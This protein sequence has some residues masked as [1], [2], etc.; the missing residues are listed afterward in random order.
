MVNKNEIYDYNNLF[1]VHQNPIISYQKFAKLNKDII[2]FNNDLESLLVI[3]REIKYEIKYHFDNVVR[4]VY[5]EAKLD[6]YGSSLYQLDIESSDL[7]L[8]ICT[9]EQ[10]NLDDLVAYLNNI[11]K[12]KKYLNINFIK[13]ASIP[14]IK[15]DVDF[16]K[17]N[18]KKVKEM[19]NKLNNNNYFQ[20][21]VK[22]N[23]YNDTN[24]I[25]V[26]ISLNSINYK[27]LNFINQGI[28]QF[29]QIIFLIKILKK[30]LIYKHM[31]NSYKGGMSSYCLF[32]ILYSYLKFYTNY[33]QSNSIENNYGSLL[34][35]FLFYYIICIDFKYTI[36]NPLSDNPFKILK[37]PIESVPTIIEPTTKKNAGK[38]IYRIFDVVNALN[39][40]Y[41]DIYIILKKD[42]NDDDNYV[43]ELFKH[44]IEN[45]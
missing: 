7:D 6:I 45:G 28:K 35:G 4:K 32:L 29:P 13:T 44:Y 24:I 39:E 26:D 2:D 20:F 8:S 21:C 9:E 30:L 5:K 15:I 3:L 23:F 11:N 40:I 33:Y 1:V 37:F 22:N 36:I 18:N 19:I 10:I 17:L 31:N 43:Y 14:I 27:Q 42:F 38:N 34:I 25:K 41:R 12:D 16:F